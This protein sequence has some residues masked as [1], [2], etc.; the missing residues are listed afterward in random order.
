MIRQAF[1]QPSLSRA[2]LAKHSRRQ[3]HSYEHENSP[4]FTP[5]ESSILSAGLALVPE[6]GFTHAT[7]IQGARDVGYRD[8]STNL[9]PDGVFALVRYHLA[10]QRLALASKHIDEE[11]GTALQVKELALKR[12]HANAPIIH[13]WQEVRLISLCCSTPLTSPVGTFPHGCSLAHSCL[14]T[15][16]GPP[17][18]R[19]SVPGRRLEC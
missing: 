7:L 13:R 18:R 14:L 6:L 19:D 4:S 9:F 5:T 8:I 11:L 1:R 12:L 17:F 2:L 3:Y 15:R 10:T 16:A